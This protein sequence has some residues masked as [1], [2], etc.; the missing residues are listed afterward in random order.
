[1]SNKKV[2]FC[3]FFH[4][5][6]LTLTIKMV[7]AV[8][9]TEGNQPL[10]WKSFSIKDKRE[11]VIAIDASVSTDISRCQACSQVGLLYMY[12]TRF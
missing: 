8:L 5:G 10:L 2:S 3:S 12:Y 4:L 6:I 1:M 9:A 11:Y 7:T